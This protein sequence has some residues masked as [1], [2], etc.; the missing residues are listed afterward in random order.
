MYQSDSNNTTAVAREQ[1]QTPKPLPRSFFGKSTV[2]E[3][4]TIYQRPSY[5]LVNQTGS[6]SFMYETTS[7]IGKMDVD[8]T[9]DLSHMHRAKDSHPT[10][11]DIHPVA[12]SGSCHP[13]T[14]T[15]DMSGS[16]TF[17]YQGGF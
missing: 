2:A 7:S 16:V 4:L 11:L 5:V 12:W 3:Q 13:G 1:K 10:R 15:N 9:Y 6:F 14:L 8:G 17:V